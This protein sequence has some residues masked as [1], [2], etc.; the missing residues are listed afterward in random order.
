MK[1]KLKVVPSSSRDCLMGWLD[2]ALKVKIKAPP[3]NGKANIAVEKFMAKS[4]NISPKNVEIISGFT[5][6]NKTLEIKGLE[7]KV[8]LEKLNL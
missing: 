2:D 7:E 6:T 1:L 5:Q 3:E 4:L 8:I